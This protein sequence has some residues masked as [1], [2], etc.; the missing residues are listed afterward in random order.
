MGSTPTVIPEATMPYAEGR[1]F[2]DAD[3][4]LMELPSFVHDHADPSVRPLLPPLGMDDNVLA[5][6]ARQLDGRTGHDPA[7]V[8]ELEKNVI[9]GPK[10]YEALGAFNPTERTRALDLLGFQCQLV[11]P[12][13][14]AGIFLW[15]DDL[16]AR[17][18]GCRAH[19]RAMAEF[20]ADDPRLLGVGLVSLADPERA[21]IELDAAIDLGLAAMWIPAEPAGGRSPGHDVFEPFWARLAEA[22]MP[23]VLHVGGSRLQ[24]RDEYMNTG[25]PVPTDWLGGGE[26]VRG[27]DLPVLHQP[28]EEF[29]SVLVLDG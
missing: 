24:I 29:L 25:R 26:N 9:G 16:D 23:F 17:Y 4:H 13:F 8:A 11:F 1:Y 5:E 6:A 27:K 2:F 19:N 10:G 3:S 21:L 7:T 22:R 12:T 18:G 14:S 20:C 15:L 28:A